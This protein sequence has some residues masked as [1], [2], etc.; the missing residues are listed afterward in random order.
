MNRN[1][2]QTLPSILIALGFCVWFLCNGNMRGA[3]I[4]GALAAFL[5]AAVVVLVRMDRDGR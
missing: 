4:M 2:L 3:A 1:L 5:A